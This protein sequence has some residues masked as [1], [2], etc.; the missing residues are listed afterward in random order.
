MPAITA[1][2]SARVS[3]H[4]EEAPRRLLDGPPLPGTAAH[5]PQGPS[6]TSERLWEAMALYHQQAGSARGTSLDH[7]AHCPWVRGPCCFCHGRAWPD[8]AAA[9]FPCLVPRAGST[10]KCRGRR[11]RRPSPALCCSSGRRRAHHRPEC[12]GG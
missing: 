1:P 5:V 6:L 7:P 8:G 12:P 10:I 4:V 2:I 3:R 9:R 11:G